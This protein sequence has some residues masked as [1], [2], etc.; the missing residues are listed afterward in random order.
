MR[1]L[2]GRLKEQERLLALATEGSDE[3]YDHARHHRAVTRRARGSPDTDRPIVVGP[4]CGEVGFELLYWIPFVRWLVD[5]A[6]IEGRRLVVVTRGGA[7]VWY[8]DLAEP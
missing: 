3:L 4:W 8:R 5:R 2:L 7:D 6:R 1:E